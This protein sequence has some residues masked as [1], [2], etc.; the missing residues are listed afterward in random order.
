M[1]RQY[2]SFDRQQGYP[3]GPGIYLECGRCGEILPSAPPDSMMCRCRNIRIDV[4]GGR[5]AVADDT[6]L[7]A[8]SAVDAL[9][10]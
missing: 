3:A 2:L 8:F 10:P 4:D 7:R 9:I 6:L 5:L 1:T